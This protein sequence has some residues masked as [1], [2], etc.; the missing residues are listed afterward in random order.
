[1]LNH[2]AED[3]FNRGMDAW[4]SGNRLEA[5]ARFEAAI[6]LERRI[7]AKSIQARY[8]SWYGLSLAL[9]RRRIHE[10]VYFCREATAKEHYNPDLHWNLARAC[11]AAGRRREAHEAIEAGLR[12]HPEHDGILRL[13]AELGER[14]RPVLPFLARHNALNIVLGKV[15]YSGRRRSS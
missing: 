12:L 5:L 14:R 2:A 7:G 9:Q 8:L 3:S 10:G 4:R 13:R 15:A 6:E 11:V 1:M